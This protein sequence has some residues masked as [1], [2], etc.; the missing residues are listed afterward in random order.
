MRSPSQT[1]I[2][3]ATQKHIVARLRLHDEMKATHC[4]AGEQHSSAA[5]RIDCSL[6]SMALVKVD[7]IVGYPSIECA[8][9]VFAHLARFLCTVNAALVERGRLATYLKDVTNEAQTM[10]ELLGPYEDAVHS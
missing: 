7:I 1:Y 3:P 10:R 2:P 8:I 6:G 9:K 5:Q 4:S